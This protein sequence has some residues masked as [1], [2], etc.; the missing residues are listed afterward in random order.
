MKKYRILREDGIYSMQVRKFFIWHD[1]GKFHKSQDDAIIDIK[2][3][4]N[5]LK[6]GVVWASEVKGNKHGNS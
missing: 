2:K 1:F 4:M 3:H 6:P 5:I